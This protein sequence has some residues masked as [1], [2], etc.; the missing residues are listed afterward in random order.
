MKTLRLLLLFS[1]TSMACGCG[2]KGPLVLPDAEHPHKK[3]KLPAP[4]KAP[5]ATKSPAPPAAPAPGAAPAS[6]APAPV[7]PPADSKAES[8]P[9]DSTGPNSPPE[10]DSQR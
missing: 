2:Q 7:A 5:A 10:L 9:G 1:L 8:A 6:P 3:L 4:P